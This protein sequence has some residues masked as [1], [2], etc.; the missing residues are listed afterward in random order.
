MIQRYDTGLLAAMLLRIC[1]T[2]TYLSS[3]IPFIIATV[4]LCIRTPNH[5]IPVKSCLG[6]LHTSK[7][8]PS[9]AAYQ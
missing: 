7:V 5:C 2:F 1:C 6:S 3:V 4:S 9:F 8:V